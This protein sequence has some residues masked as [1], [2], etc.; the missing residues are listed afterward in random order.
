MD[1]T[2]GKFGDIDLVPRLRESIAC[3]KI[4]QYSVSKKECNRACKIQTSS[5][6][7]SS[8]NLKQ[9]KSYKT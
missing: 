5:L 1:V 6:R 2:K 3:A 4:H 8:L 9:N 7:G